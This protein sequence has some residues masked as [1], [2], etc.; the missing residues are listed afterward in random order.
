MEVINQ[1]PNRSRK[2]SIIAVIKTNS[3]LTPGEIIGLKCRRV[4]YSW[5]AISMKTYLNITYHTAMVEYLLKWLSWCASAEG[6]KFA[7]QELSSISELGLSIMG[8]RICRDFLAEAPL[9]WSDCHSEA[10]ANFKLNEVR[11]PFL[12]SRVKEVGWY[13]RNIKGRLILG[14][15]AMVNL[16]KIMQD[17]DRSMTKFRIVKAVIS[18]GIM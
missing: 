9:L 11:F 8:M 15:K 16:D 2:C 4:F 17:K 18:L 5:G 12:G 7:K 10:S 13:T 6:L 3:Y 1:Q 14:R